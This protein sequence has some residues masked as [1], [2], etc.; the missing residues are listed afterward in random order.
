MV[1]FM[2]DLAPITKYLNRI[3]VALEGIDKSLDRIV[4]IV[5]QPAPKQGCGGRNC[6]R[7]KKD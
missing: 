5:D 4:E 3:A 7:T 2:P 1:S 6:G